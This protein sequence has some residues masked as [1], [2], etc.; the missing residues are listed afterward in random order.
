MI[1]PK[2]ITLPNGFRIALDNINHVNSATIS[3]WCNVG[4]RVENISNNGICHFLEHMVFKGTKTRSSYDISEEI[5]SKGGYLNAW[6][7]KE[8]T[9]FYA[10][11]LKNDVAIGINILFDM[12]QNSIFDKEELEK[13]KGVILEEIKMYLDSPSDLVYNL[14]EKICYAN[15]TLAMPIIGTESNVKSFQ[16]EDF[17][18]HINTHYTADNLLFVISG[19]FNEEEVI[20]EVSKFASQFKTAQ[21][22]AT[23]IIPKF[24]QAKE[25]L[26]KNDIEQT[27]II[28]GL[29]GYSY[30]QDNYYQLSIANA[31]LG[32][33]MSSRLFSEIREK[34][35]LA[36]SIDSFLNSYKDCGSFAVQ[37]GCSKQNADLVINLIK[38]ELNKAQDNITEKELQK[39][40]NQLK[41]SILMSLESTYSRAERIANNLMNFGQIR[42]LNDLISKIDNSS[43][44]DINKILSY[45]NNQEASIAIVMPK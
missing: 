6:T 11:V 21:N 12:L 2:I 5:E 7:S 43:I 34:R 29:N 35:G 31:I 18:N 13:E 10:K 15:S 19:N 37:V 1:N 42:D 33:G 9:T 39:A 27:N 40:K 44:A 25:I 24:T 20:N 16:S 36:Y 45:L 3:I 14:Y 23:S 17:F 32:G 8:K 4:S 22:I 38:E 41:S 30:M 28:F 26:T